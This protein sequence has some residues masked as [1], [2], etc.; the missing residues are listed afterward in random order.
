MFNVFNHVNYANPDANV[1]Y[2]NG[3]LA[4]TTSGTITG[5]SGGQRIIQVGAHLTF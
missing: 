1:G 4:D 2:I 5:P 3:G